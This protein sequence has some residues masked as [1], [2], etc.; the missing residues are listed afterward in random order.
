M[1]TVMSH[2]CRHVFVA[3]M[4]IPVLNVQF[5]VASKSSHAEPRLA[6]HFGA[7]IGIIFAGMVKLNVDIKDKNSKGGTAVSNVKVQSHK[8]LLEF[9]YSKSNWFTL[10]TRMFTVLRLH[11]ML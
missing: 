5:W 6:R 3:C 10:T 4:Y 7:N 9:Q 2:Y 1:S 8:Y 11:D